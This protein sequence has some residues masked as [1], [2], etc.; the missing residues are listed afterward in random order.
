LQSAVEVGEGAAKERN[1]SL[2]GC[3]DRHSAGVNLISPKVD[4]S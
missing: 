4:P 1:R 2:P 3:A